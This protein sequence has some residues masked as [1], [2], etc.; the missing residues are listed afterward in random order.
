M[1]G[2]TRIG[3]HV[4]WILNGI[5]QITPFHAANGTPTTVYNVLAPRRIV[6]SSVRDWN[7]ITTA[8]NYPY[9]GQC[10]SINAVFNV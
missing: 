5:I 7:L 3:N 2:L 4:T 6:F 8:D 1:E 9:N 10:Y